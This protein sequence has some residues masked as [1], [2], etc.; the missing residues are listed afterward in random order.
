MKKQKILLA[1]LLSAML[2]ACGE[3]NDYSS[4]YYEPVDTVDLSDLYQNDVTTSTSDLV[5]ET[6]DVNV[7]MDAEMESTVQA[8]TANYYFYA[9]YSGTAYAD[10]AF[11]LCFD[12]G[13]MLLPLSFTNI[14]SPMSLDAAACID[15]TGNVKYI[16]KDEHVGTYDFHEGKL[17]IT[18]KQHPSYRISPNG[19]VLYT[20]DNTETLFS[21]VCSYF[22]AVTEHPS[23]FDASEPFSYLLDEKGT[24]FLSLP[25]G[26]PLYNNMCA[27]E[28]VGFGVIRY[29]VE[30][31]GNFDPDIYEYYSAENGIVFTNDESDVIVTE[32]NNYARDYY[33]N[34]VSLKFDEFKFGAVFDTDDGKLYYSDGRSEEIPVEDYQVKSPYLNGYIALHCNDVPSVY[35]F[36]ESKLYT[37]DALS[38]REILQLICRENGMLVYTVKGNDEKPYYVVY[39]S[40]G[41]TIKD[42]TEQPSEYGSI[43]DVD[44]DYVYFENGIASING[45]KSEYIGEYIRCGQVSDGWALC[46]IST[47]EDK[48]TQNYNF[49]NSNGEFLLPVDAN[50][51]T[52]INVDDNV[53]VIEILCDCM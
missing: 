41:N 9:Q 48:Y 45:T 43:I 12:N 32:Y 1:F 47:T 37:F 38:G 20:T 8:A 51:F 30:D 14:L 13:Y 53:P 35:N 46:E 6:T 52:C 40:H 27:V 3:N 2:T 49:V 22:T 29:L 19:E 36:D 7:S 33:G 34:L 16:I 23:G 31:G 25:T 39:D 10:E 50:G 18:F 4:R 28:N 21:E 5:S 44:S 42:I 17:G 26:I 15:S 11:N 24:K